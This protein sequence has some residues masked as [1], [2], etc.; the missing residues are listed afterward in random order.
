MSQD[1]I[2]KSEKL[3]NGRK[4]RLDFSLSATLLSVW[5]NVLRDLFYLFDKLCYLVLTTT[6]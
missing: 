2:W 3:F 1:E 5:M 6:F 4:S